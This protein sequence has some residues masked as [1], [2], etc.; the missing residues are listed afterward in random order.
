MNLLWCVLCLL[1]AFWVLTFLPLIS[2]LFIVKRDASLATRAVPFIS[3][4]TSKSMHSHDQ[5]PPN[6]SVSDS[7][8]IT[9]LETVEIQSRSIQFI[10]ARLSAS[11]DLS[12]LTEGVI[13]PTESF[14]LPKHIVI[15]RSLSTVTEGDHTVVQVMNVS[16]GNITLCK[17]TPMGEFTPIQ[18][19]LVV[20]TVN[21]DQVSAHT[22]FPVVDID[23]SSSDL[24]PQERTKLHCKN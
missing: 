20:D 13:D 5:N 3:P 4:A 11:Y 18:N 6:H 15:A 14:A 21:C 10:T 22:E 8:L 1:T 19:V 16:P 7:H 17:G 2:V 12:K 24:S 9:V 23:L